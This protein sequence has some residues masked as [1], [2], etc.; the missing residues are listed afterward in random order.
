MPRA[1]NN[2]ASRKRR[3]RILKRAKGFRGGRGK[4]LRTA[5]ETVKRAMVYATRDRKTK[6][7]VMR[8]LWTVRI[9]AA[10]RMCGLSYSKF[11]S[12]L[13]LA[14]VELNRKILA[15][16]AVNDLETFKQIAELAKQNVA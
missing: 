15:E 9:N 7:R 3:K 10:A 1:T 12:G 11:M 4:L 16:L 5:T 6:K 2:P 14:K 13:K 8:R